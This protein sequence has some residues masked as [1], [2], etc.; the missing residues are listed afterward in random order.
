IIKEVLGGEATRSAV[1]GFNSYV[2]G[3]DPTF[4]PYSYDLNRAKAVLKQANFPPPGYKLIL[5]AEPERGAPDMPEV[6]E[7]IAG[8]WSA[9]GITTEVRP[10][11]AAIRGPLVTAQSIPNQAFTRKATTLSYPFAT[12]Q[13]NQGCSK[14]FNGILANRTTCSPE[15]EIMESYP[16]LKTD[17]ERTEAGK[18]IQRWWYDNYFDVP[19]ASHTMMLAAGPRVREGSWVPQQGTTYFDRLWEAKPR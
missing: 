2:A 1:Y 13:A 8:Y 11:T 3:Y 16:S 7:A 9:L 5:L 18:K 15:D 6:A 19:V 4:T 10:T 17:A 12:F 14:T